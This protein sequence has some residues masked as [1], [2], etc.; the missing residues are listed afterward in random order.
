MKPVKDSFK[1]LINQA[2]ESSISRKNFLIN[3]NETYTYGQLISNLRKLHSHFSHKGINTGDKVLISLENDFEMICMS[4]AVISYG[5]TAVIMEPCTNLNRAKVILSASEVNGWVVDSNSTFKNN[6]PNCDLELALERPLKSKGVLNKLLKKKE[7]EEARQTLSYVLSKEEELDINREIDLNQPATIIFTSGTTSDP[8][9]VVLTHGNILTHLKTLSEQYELNTN[10]VI[11]NILPLYHVDG[12]FQGSLLAFY[13]R[14]VLSRPVRF[15]IQRIDDLLHSIYKHRVTHFFSVPTILKLIN[16]YGQDWNDSFETEDFKFVIS[17]AGFLDETLWK[18][19]MTNFKVKVLNSYGL[20]ETVAAGIFCGTTDDNW[21]MGS[22]G[23]PQD[24]EA[25]IIDE[26]GVEIEI[27]QI[28]ELCLRGSNIMPSYLMPTDNPDAEGWFRTGDLAMKDSDDFYYIKGRLKNLIIR[29]GINIYPDEVVE[30]LSL[31]PEIEDLHVYG[32]PDDVWGERV[33][34]VLV[35]KE[36]S[37]FDEMSV[38]QF[39]KEKLDATVTPDV[40]HFVEKIPRGISGKVLGKEVKSIIEKL[41]NQSAE[42]QSNGSL[43]EEIIELAMKCFNTGIT[44]EQVNAPS[45]SIQGWNSLEHLQFVTMI[46]KTFDIKLDTREI[47]NITSI[48]KA[49]DLVRDKLN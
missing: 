10:S 7:E 18:K 24:L 1:S 43:Q 35:K 32:E 49:I 9:G 23:K 44:V 33:V 11:S 13:N 6:L 48:S 47:M 30:N 17:N 26:N 27:N 36:S 12:F 37:P 39:C 34:A 20:T 46:E 21:R 28:G 22:I 29:G 14:I 8:K 19:F 38:L 5:A 2:S 40:V 41:Q 4:L 16:E 31:H 3:E 15:E 45:Q 42:N 25:K